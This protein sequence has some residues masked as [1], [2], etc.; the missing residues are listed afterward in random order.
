LKYCPLGSFLGV[1]AK[2]VYKVMT[3]NL[4]LKMKVKKTRESIVGGLTMEKLNPCKGE[5]DSERSLSL[6]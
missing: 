4:P 1:T 2:I 6:R 3:D 5:E